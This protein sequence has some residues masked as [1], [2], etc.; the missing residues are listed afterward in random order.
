M[1]I[2]KTQ[3]LVEDEDQLDEVL[4]TVCVGFNREVLKE[5]T[6]TEAR[7]IQKAVQLHV[8]VPDSAHVLGVGINTRLQ[9][10]EQMA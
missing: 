2:Q 8:A 4:D 1:V 3:G 6:V 7:L 10:L 5:A 9:S